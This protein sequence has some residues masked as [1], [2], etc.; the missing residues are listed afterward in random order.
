MN[1]K[2]RINPQP[3]L[4]Y[5]NSDFSVTDKFGDT[6]LVEGLGRSIRIYNPSSEHFRPKDNSDPKTTSAAAKVRIDKIRQ[7]LKLEKLKR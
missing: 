4:S 5:K 2:E 7:E 1:W 3:G 6:L